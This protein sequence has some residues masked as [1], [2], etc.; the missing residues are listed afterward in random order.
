MKTRKIASITAGV[1]LSCVLLIISFYKVDFS[2][3]LRSFR[4]ISVSS[5]LLCTLFMC[6]SDL[7]RS[8]TWRI[9]TRKIKP[10][11]AS[12]LF[13]GVVVGYMVNTLLPF[14]AG[15]L[16]RAQY[17]AS[18]VGVR[19]STALSTIFIERVFDVFSL[20]LLLILC[21]Y[22]GIRGLSFGAAEIVLVVWLI[23]IVLTTLLVLNLEALERNKHHLTLV[24]ER[25]LEMLV[26]FLA[27]LQ[28]LRDPRN[29][30]AILG[31]TML[32]WLCNYFSI[33]ALIHDSGAVTKYQAALIL[34]MFTN[35]GFLI[36]STPGALGIIQV[37]FW[38]ALSPFGLP[39]EHAL[40]LSFA[41]VGI[42]FLFNL[43]V[44]LPYFM[45]AH[46]KWGQVTEDS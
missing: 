38:L 4:S 13:G 2:A 30:L 3:V 5:L 20:G 21:I 27:P 6:F 43:G 12:T 29:L 17:L 31:T 44:G 8:L 9:T 18:T 40:A 7:A 32:V 25:V 23:C 42:I 14:R 34:F 37:A 36:P 15:E 41:Y 1:I 35:L 10:I 28:Q 39:K 33:L 26:H 16:F 11:S 46:L 45:K 19:R 24:P 22:Y